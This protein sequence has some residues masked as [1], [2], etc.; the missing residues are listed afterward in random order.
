ML[1][2]VEVRGNILEMAVLVGVEHLVHE[3][4]VPEVVAGPAL[5][6]DLPRYADIRWCL[7]RTIGNAHDNTQL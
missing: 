1:E 7:Q 4:H 5:V 3:V 2:H 6:L